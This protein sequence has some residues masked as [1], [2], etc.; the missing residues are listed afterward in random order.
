MESKIDFSQQRVEQTNFELN[1]TENQFT[2]IDSTSI[3]QSNLLRRLPGQV[4]NRK[5]P[6]SFTQKALTFRCKHIQK[7]IC[8]HPNSIYKTHLEP[9][10]NGCLVSK[11]SPNGQF[12]AYSFNSDY[13]IQIATVPDLKVINTL[14][15]HTNFV[16]DLDWLADK[17]KN[18]FPLHL[19]SASSDRT[20]VVWTI[21]KDRVSLTVSYLY[22]DGEVNCICVYVYAI[23]H[24]IS[25]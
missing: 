17:R 11:F 22:G 25:T 6:V 5:I 15:G 21:E 8:K 20:A 9:S 14:R 16:Y 13:N 23:I 24:H 18:S 19:V 2:G 4:Y 1:G 12:L 3:V 7:Q 10:S